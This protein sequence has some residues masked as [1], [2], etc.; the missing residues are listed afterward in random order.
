LIA[1][2]KDNEWVGFSV[3]EAL[4]ALKEESS[5]EAVQAM[6]GNPSETLRYAAIE[7][8]GKIGSPRSITALLGRLA[9]AT[10]IEKTAIIRSLVQIGITPSMAEVGDLLIGLYTQG[11]WEDRL[12]ALAGL[13]DLKDKRAVPVILEGAGSL[14][15]SLPESEERLQAVKE[16]LL[17]F[18]CTPSLIGAINDPAVK[19]RS[20][21]IAIEAIG[22]LQCTEA[23]PLLIEVLDGDLREVRRAGVKAL[24]AIRGDQ[25][26]AE[27]RK[28]IE[29][30]DGHVRNAAITALGLIGD[31]T[32]FPLILGHIERENYS[33]VL[34]ATMKAL[35]MIDEQ[36]LFSQ[37]DEL[38][39]QA[40]E[41]IARY[42]S[43]Q[44]GL[45]TLSRDREVN[46]RLAALAGLNRFPDERTRVRMREALDDSDRET[47]K[48]AVMAL[49]SMNCCFD[50]IAHALQD[51]DLWVRLYAVRAM[52]DSGRPEAAKNIVPLLNDNETPVVL[53]T[54]D[55][56]VRLGGSEVIALG[57][58]RNHPDQAVRERVAQVMER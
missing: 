55:A 2:L 22:E 10:G 30:R 20:Q 58:L 32:S 21:V 41:M 45:L 51:G 43:T 49:G 11:E 46:V 23:V 4:A 1:A 19:F 13:A 56:L 52:R 47:R 33:D 26:L 16:A 29:D 12:I 50:E 31:E 37:L 24:A 57:A 7:T 17:K 3:L 34:E 14:D 18:G 27:L 48:L 35:L 28:R 5:I 44:N 40:R 42:A 8:L 15:P 38:S 9:A 53:A 39:S 25:A 36:K 6:L 54:I